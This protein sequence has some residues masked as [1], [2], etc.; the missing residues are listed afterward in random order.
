MDIDLNDST[1]HLI[2]GSQ[3][4]ISGKGCLE[5]M[6]QIDTLIIFNLILNIITI[7]L[8][9]FFYDMKQS[10]QC[11]GKLVSKTKLSDGQSYMKK[12]QM[13]IDDKEMKPFQKKQ[14]N[15]TFMRAIQV[16]SFIDDTNA[17]N[18]VKNFQRMTFDLRLKENFKIFL[19]G[20]SGSGKTSFI[21]K[22]IENIDN[23][24]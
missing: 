4:M 15:K 22:L 20:P 21:I 11:K 6:C 12:A 5:V 7:I 18:L 10:K 16:K 13:E 17:V 19:S 8:L 14:N 24:S 2:L 1:N 3:E 23:A 9:I